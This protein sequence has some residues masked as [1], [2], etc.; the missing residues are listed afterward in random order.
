M[1][2]RPRREDP[3]RH[4]ARLPGDAE[5][6]RRPRRLVRPAEQRLKVTH[7]VRVTR[8]APVVR[9]VR[10]SS[11]LHRPRA[12]HRRNAR[13]AV[14]LA[15][16]D[17]GAR[18]ESSRPQAR[19]SDGHCRYASCARGRSSTPSTAHETKR[20]IQDRAVSTAGPS[21]R[22]S[23]HVRAASGRPSDVLDHRLDH[24]Q[25]FRVQTLRA[26]A[27]AQALARL[28]RARRLGEPFAH[29]RLAPASPSWANACAW[30]FV[31]P[32]RR[33]GVEAMRPRLSHRRTARAQVPP[34]PGPLRT[35]ADG[36]ARSRSCACARS[37]SPASW[38]TYAAST[39]RRWSR[40]TRR[41]ESARCPFEKERGGPGAPRERLAPRPL[42]R[43]RNRLVRLLDGCSQVPRARLPDRPRAPRAGR[44]WIGGE[45]NRSL[46]RIAASNGCVKRMRSARRRRC[47]PRPPVPNH[48]RAQHLMQPR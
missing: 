28:R 26:Q 13:C 24:Q 46:V 8:R 3:G 32:P 34:V 12:G 19:D 20:L 16:H 43:A 41:R 25:G 9:P 18:A 38:W 31:R 14:D 35:G 11:A 1:A 23:S 29:P 21:A 36:R 42:E 40:R 6:T 10:R 33:L 17:V 7:G 5:S 45:P 15:E 2:E 47:A 48:L 22:A 37:V 30:R 27:L 39:L 44:P 4:P